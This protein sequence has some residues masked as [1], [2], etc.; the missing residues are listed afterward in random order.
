MNIKRIF[1][2]ILTLLGIVGLIYGAV[3]FVNMNN[4]NKDIRAL[5]IYGILG[6]V[7]L[8]SGISLVRTVKDEA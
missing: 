8:F 1:G 3:L 2:S 5:V 4:G 7:F 6:L